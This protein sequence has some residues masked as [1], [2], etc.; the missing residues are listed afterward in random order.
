MKHHL[1]LAECLST[2]WALMPDRLQVAAGVLH[3]WACGKTADHRT[4]AEIAAYRQAR[5][6]RRETLAL[7]TL[8]GI[9]VLP[10]YG[11]LAQRANMVDDISGPG[12]TSTQLFA[13]ALRQACS[14]DTVGA[15]LIDIDSPGGSVFGAAELAD[16]IRQARSSKPIYAIANSQA[17]SAA[18]WVGCAAGELYVTPSGEVGSIGVWQMHSDYSRMLDDD[19]VRTTLIAAGKYKIEG[20]PYQPLEEGA[21]AFLQTRVDEYYAAFTQAV[22]GNRGVPIDYVRHGMGEGRMLGAEAALAEKM[23]DGILTFDALVT[24]VQNKIRSGRQNKTNAPRR[25]AVERQLRLL[26]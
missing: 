25:A 12:G 9:A 26:G 10:L 8:D 13:R 17:G 3:H 5:D 7:N 20:N 4:L 23:V 24:R 21:R 14:D 2:P 11:V 19:G 18:Y 6:T 15:I 1:L 22:A 16:I